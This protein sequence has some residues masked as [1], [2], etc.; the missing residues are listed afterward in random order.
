MVDVLN[1]IEAAYQ[2]DMPA[3]DW[4]QT[5]GTL[6]YKQF[7]TGRGLYGC[8]YN[9]K[10]DGMLRIGYELKLD[11]PE[12]A[13]ALPIAQTLE[14]LPP[15][16]TEKTF[17]RTECITQSEIVDPDIAPMIE[18][19]SASM[20]AIG[21]EDILIC[22]GCD[23]AGHGAFF[24]AFLPAKQKIDLGLRDMWTRTV[25]HVVAALRLRRRLMDTQ[26]PVETA[27]AVLKPSGQID[28][29]DGEAKLDEAREQ[30]R[31][32]VL[33]VE[34]ARGRMRR[35]NP[36]TAVESWKCLVSTR[37]S[38]VDQFESDGKR[39]ILAHRNDVS[40]VGLDAL[41]P[42]E[43]QALAFAAIGHSNKLIAYELGITASTVGVLLHTAASKLGTNSREALIAAYQKLTSRA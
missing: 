24:G 40:V 11:F 15:Q 42:R 1:V 16:F 36:E 29:A 21:L 22:A 2:M 13:L 7:G 25:Q 33:A 31:E 34:S 12:P 30:L 14:M 3:A 32:A 27:D 28:H 43:R 41:T 20:S 9:V 38:L 5:I 37:W 6:L 26:A 4:I 8:E 10:P 39:Y 18:G 17:R 35:E 19:A 23:P